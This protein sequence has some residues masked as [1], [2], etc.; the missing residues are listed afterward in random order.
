MSAANTYDPL[1]KRKPITP[2]PGY[3]PRQS[4]FNGGGPQI[5]SR[6]SDPLEENTI[7][8]PGQGLSQMP[9]TANRPGN[10]AFNQANPKGIQTRPMSTAIPELP[11]VGEEGNPADVVQSELPQSQARTPISMRRPITPVAG[12]PV[13]INP[14]TPVAVP[15][16]ADLGPAAGEPPVVPQRRPIS[17][18]A[19]ARPAPAPN[20]EMGNA[21]SAPEPAP[22]P[23]RRP[24][25][26]GPSAPDVSP[27]QQ[28]LADLYAANGRT[29]GVPLSDQQ[30]AANDANES[31][32]AKR[33]AAIAQAYAAS[34]EGQDQLDRRQAAVRSR[35]P[36]TNRQQL[37]AIQDQRRQAEQQQVQNS[38]A[39][40][41]IDTPVRVAETQGNTQ[42]KLA[43]ITTKSAQEIARANNLSAQQQAELEGMVKK[44]IADSQLAGTKDT[45]AAGMVNT[46]TTADASV[47]G[48]EVGAG[49]QLGVA[50]INAQS[51]TAKAQ[52]D[53]AGKESERKAGLDKARMDALG[54]VLGKAVEGAGITMDDTQ[55]KAFM[56]SIG[57][58]F[59]VQAGGPVSNPQSIPGPSNRPLPSGQQE[60]PTTTPTQTSSRPDLPRVG[61]NQTIPG[62]KFKKKVG[63]DTIVYD[64]NERPIAIIQG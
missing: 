50:G 25:S 55:R 60:T 54:N 18:M 30:Q 41:Q 7:Y 53:A 13:G 12:A 22:A 26:M 24:I 28:A 57:T 17:M 49:A 21:P 44:Y 5:E 51:A 40:R 2:V 29:L 19:S 32:Q 6:S 31:A 4:I 46:K 27:N 48:A 52:A 64:Q 42:T 15:T 9:A 43:D 8:N 63:N 39:A 10:L 11:G 20:P 3:Q 35:M 34:P 58:I 56:D 14:G 45:N 47:K 1:K 61:A 38:L 36:I 16:A 59:G 33:R 62:A 37:M 23:V